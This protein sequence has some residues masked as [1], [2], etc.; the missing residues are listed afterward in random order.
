MPGRPHLTGSPIQLTRRP[1]SFGAAGVALLLLASSAACGALE[2]RRTEVTAAQRTACEA[3]VEA[4][5]DRV[6]DQPRRETSGNPLGAA[7]G[8]PPIVLRCGVPVPEDYTRFA[9]C[10]TVN[11]LDWFVPDEASEDQ[12]LDAVLTTVGREPRVELVVPAERRPPV[13][14]MVDVGDAIKAHTKVVRRC[15]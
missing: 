9:G 6:S 12:G 3:L 2:V 14:A 15:R 13:A 1:S 8:D 4:L 5:P 11:D 10:Q 7:W